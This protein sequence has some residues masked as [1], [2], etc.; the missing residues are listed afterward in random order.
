MGEGASRRSR[1]LL[2]SVVSG[3]RVLRPEPSLLEAAVDE[4]AS[5]PPGAAPEAGGG[6]GANQPPGGAAEHAAEAPLLGGVYSA[7]EGEGE[8]G[9]GAPRD[10]GIIIGAGDDDS[11]DGSGIS[12]PR[13]GKAGVADRD[14]S[15]G[16]SDR[17]AVPNAGASSR[18][19]DEPEGAQAEADVSRCVG[20]SAGTASLAL[21]APGAASSDGGGSPAA[22]TIAR[23]GEGGLLVVAS[24]PVPRMARIPLPPP[25]RLPNGAVPTLAFSGML[26]L[27]IG[28]TSTGTADVTC[29]GTCI[30]S[31]A[32]M[33]LTSTGTSTGARVEEVVATGRGTWAALWRGLTYSFTW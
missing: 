11:M 16:E 17:A 31:G 2:P 6:C 3:E 30:R 4:S 25:S 21:D 26:P 7:C 27:P 29:T 22:T 24:S 1:L 23:T 19:T 20:Q 32:T 18:D 12:Q 14:V 5:P 9:G 13:I 28:S 8:S 33:P 15:N 10:G